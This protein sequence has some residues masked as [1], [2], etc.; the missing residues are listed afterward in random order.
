[1]VLH[2][3][4]DIHTHNTE[5]SSKV[6]SVVNCYPNPLVNSYTYRY[7]SVGLHPWHIFP[8]KWNQDFELLT[9]YTE[10]KNCVSLGECGLDRLKGPHIKLQIEVFVK[11]IQLAIKCSKPIIIHCVKAYDL[12]IPLIN[13]YH[14][15]Q[16]FIIHGFNSKY[17]IAEQLLKYSCFFSFGRALI[18]PRNKKLH[19]LFKTLPLSQVFLET[20]QSEI[21][22]SHLYAFASEC[23]NE[24]TEQL[25]KSLYKN[26]YSVFSPNKL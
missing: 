6:I 10:Q 26:F 20:D 16:I 24:T 11:Q 13:E 4:V 8:E 7:I 19:H 12:L 1:M 9:R 3:F 23:R 17:Q 14:K 22:I 18:D 15:D 21:P 2:P 5:S 25:K